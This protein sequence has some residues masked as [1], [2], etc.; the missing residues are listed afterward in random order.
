M[1]QHLDRS[2]QLVSGIAAEDGGSQKVA[3]KT[4][5]FQWHP[6]NAKRFSEIVYRFGGVALDLLKLLLG[7]LLNEEMQNQTL[8]VF[9]LHLIAEG[10]VRLVCGLI[11]IDLLLQL[12]VESLNDALNAVDL[13]VDLL[14]RK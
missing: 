14:A 13:F 6:E 8:S 3:E 9:R 2:G 7:Q 4:L 10:V 1:G 5:V 11:T 12:P